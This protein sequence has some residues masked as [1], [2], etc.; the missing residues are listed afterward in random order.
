MESFMARMESDGLLMYACGACGVRRLEHESEADAK[1]Y[2]CIVGDTMAVLRLSEQQVADYMQVNERWRPVFSIF[3]SRDEHHYYLHPNLVEVEGFDDDGV[4]Q[5]PVEQVRLCSACIR[6]V[7]AGTKPP[8]SIANGFDY[9]DLRRV[10]LPP[11]SDVEACLISLVR[12]D[13]LVI[14]LHSIQ[15]EG[16]KSTAQRGLRGHVICYQ[17]EGAQQISQRLPSVVETFDRVDVCMVGPSKEREV[18]RR[19]VM[20][21]RPAAVNVEVVY[22]Y[23][24]FLKAV[25]PTWYGHIEIDESEETLAA[26]RSFQQRLADKAVASHDKTVIRMAQRVQSDTAAFAWVKAAWT[27]STT[28]R[29]APPILSFPTVKAT[30]T[31]T[32]SLSFGTATTSRSSDSFTAATTNNQSMSSGSRRGALL[33]LRLQ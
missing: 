13:Q 33:R 30:T 22:L 3:K 24:R 1:F 11:L 6:C 2:H 26:L 14:E 4:Q 5:A 23:L 9:G 27:W 19:G 16:K 8:Y 21:C 32:R 28:V 12:V 17:H 7:T 18:L 29:Q 20:A 10:A 15:K 31:A 25:N